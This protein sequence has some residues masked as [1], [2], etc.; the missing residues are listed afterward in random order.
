MIIKYIPLTLLRHTKQKGP[1]KLHQV[2][3]QK[4]AFPSSTFCKP[5]TTQIGHYL[6]SLHEQVSGYCRPSLF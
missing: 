2:C 1:T 6:E 3:R 4:I 5:Q